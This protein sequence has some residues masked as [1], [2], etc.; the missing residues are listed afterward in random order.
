MTIGF[1]AVNCKDGFSL[2]LGL[3][4][5]DLIRFDLISLGFN[6]HSHSLI[7]TNT[8]HPTNNDDNFLYLMFFTAYPPTPTPITKTTHSFFHPFLATQPSHP[9]PTQH[10]LLEPTTHQPTEEKPPSAIYAARAATKRIVAG[11]C[12]YAGFPAART[13]FCIDVGTWMNE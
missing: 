4:W 12:E 2:L 13:H 5:F 1:S 7:A 6:S 11:L 3:V 10:L 9:N 8:P